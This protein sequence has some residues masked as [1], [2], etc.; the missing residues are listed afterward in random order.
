MQDLMTSTSER[1]FEAT[2]GS[3]RFEDVWLTLPESCAAAAAK[4]AS[5]GG[6]A[7]TTTTLVNGADFEVTAPHPLFGARRPH[8]S[9]FAQCGATSSLRRSSSAAATVKMPY[10]MMVATGG[11]TLRQDE[12]E[13]NRQLKLA[14]E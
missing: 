10:T 9:Q 12:E 3:A 7:T 2:D 14:G 6:S 4:N 11:A 13:S 8:A 1:L 5:R